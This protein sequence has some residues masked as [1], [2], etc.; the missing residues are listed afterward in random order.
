MKKLVPILILL[1]IACSWG[2]VSAHNPFTA[3]PEKQHNAP[4]PPVRHPIFVKIILWQ[5]QLKQKMSDMIREVRATGN[6]KPFLFLFSLGFVYG[7]VHAAGPGHGK[8]VALSYLVSCGH[9]YGRALLFGNLIALFHGLSGIVFVL[10][11]HIL[12]KMTVSSTLEATTHITQ[13]ISFGLVIL[14]GLFLV[15]HSLIAWKRGF[16]S[17]AD[18]GDE[19]TIPVLS[20]PFSAALAIGMVPCPAVVLVMLFCMSVG[21]TGLGIGLSFMIAFGMATTIT[22]VVIFGLTGKKAAARLTGKSKKLSWF[23][24][25]SIETIASLA[26]VSFGLILFLSSF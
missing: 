5:H 14:L 13:K 4:K 23:V 2:P 7:V 15:I 19:Q 24:E 17:Q 26:I 18:S 16:D 3:K 1:G 11:A 21:V 25:R 20:N 8:F 6:I 12:M 10:V 9:K 22:I